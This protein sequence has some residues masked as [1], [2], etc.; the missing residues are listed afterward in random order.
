MRSDAP[1]KFNFGT[2]WLQT[3]NIPNHLT[4]TWW[5]HFSL[6]LM[7][8]QKFRTKRLKVID[9]STSYAMRATS[10]CTISKMKRLPKNAS[11]WNCIWLTT[12]SCSFHN[13]L[14]RTHLSKMSLTASL[15]PS[16]TSVK[17]IKSQRLLIVSLIPITRVMHIL[18]SWWLWFKTRSLINAPVWLCVLWLA[19]I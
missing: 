3:K 12:V 11:V 1:W 4:R 6:S 16:W 14:Q 15:T 10:R 5:V 2:K 17:W 8:F 18:T 7:S 9:T 13:F 19:K